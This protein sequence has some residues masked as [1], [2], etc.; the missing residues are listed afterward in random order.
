MRSLLGQQRS[1][2]FGGSHRGAQLLEEQVTLA[3]AAIGIAPEQPDPPLP[4]G[5]STGT[6]PKPLNGEA[7]TRKGSPQPVTGW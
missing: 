7:M 1:R 3:V 4:P 6:G 2:W 5:A